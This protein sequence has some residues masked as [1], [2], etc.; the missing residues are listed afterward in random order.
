MAGEG[1]IL[2]TLLLRRRLGEWASDM[3]AAARGRTP[4]FMGG[5][6]G[7]GGYHQSWREQRAGI[8]GN[9]RRQGWVE[10][11]EGIWIQK[12]SARLDPGGCVGGRMPEGAGL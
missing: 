5:V 6:L 8:E 11:I 3:E 12:A 2:I 9:R 7:E 10:G 4:A 1:Q